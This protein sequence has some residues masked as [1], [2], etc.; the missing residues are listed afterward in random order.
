MKTIVHM[1]ECSRCPRQ[2][3]KQSVTDEFD[4]G[5]CGCPE[6][7]ASSTLEEVKTAARD[8]LESMNAKVIDEHSGGSWST[9]AELRLRSLVA[10]TLALLFTACGPAPVPLEPVLA[11][12]CIEGPNACP[13]NDPQTQCEPCSEF[14]TREACRAS[15]VDA[16]SPWPS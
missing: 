8:L 3:E 16:G 6:Q 10:L 15:Q 1:C 2:G 5:E 11:C 7:L 14:G 12:E 13:R 4:G 9:Q